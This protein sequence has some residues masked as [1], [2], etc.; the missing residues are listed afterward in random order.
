QP[1]PVE[2]EQ[3]PAA[4][5]PENQPL[6]LEALNILSTVAAAA[7]AIT[8]PPDYATN[9]FLKA[10]QIL[11]RLLAGVN[12]QEKDF[13]LLPSG[14]SLS[15]LGARIQ[16]KEVLEVTSDFSA[17]LA[18]LRW[19]LK[20]ECCVR[21]SRSSLNHVLKTEMTPNAKKDIRK[22]L[23][24][25]KDAGMLVAFAQGG[26]IYLLVIVACARVKKDLK[27]LSSDMY[28]RLSNHLKCPDENS[29]VGKKIV[30][31]IIPAVALLQQKYPC[32]YFASLL[33]PADL[34]LF[35]IFDNVALE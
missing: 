19:R 1:E 22:Y 7:Q 13:D 10:S 32:L 14:V 2:Q 3:E 33:S 20:L 5:I 34:S 27:K 6:S 4:P 15:D 29:P 28:L 24:W 21:E 16:A 9:I 18:L 23:R 35:K 30:D 11:D 31:A 12:T 17:M 8:A 26:S 25:C